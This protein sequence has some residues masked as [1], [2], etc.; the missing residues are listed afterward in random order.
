MNGGASLLRFPLHLPPRCQTNPRVSCI[1]CTTSQGAPAR[2]S[3]TRAFLWA[4]THTTFRN[5]RL[6]LQYGFVCRHQRHWYCWWW[7]SGASARER[8]DD[9]NMGKQPLRTTIVTPPKFW[10][11]GLHLELLRDP[12]FKTHK[13]FYLWRQYGLHLFS[14]RC[15]FRRSSTSML[16]LY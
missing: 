9:S 1:L 8:S 5:F 7:S 12:S 10:S 4:Q 6:H 2:G 15:P 14:H 13:H 11:P 16:F 3:S